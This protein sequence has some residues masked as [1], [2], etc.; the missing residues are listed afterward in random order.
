MY[1]FF[2]IL[3]RKV[4]QNTDE[5]MLLLLNVDVHIRYTVGRN[6][7]I[8]ALKWN[9]SFLNPFAYEFLTS[10]LHLNKIATVPL[11]SKKLD[12]PDKIVTLSLLN[13]FRHI[14][15]FLSFLFLKLSE[16][17]FVTDRVNYLFHGRQ[18]V[19]ITKSLSVRTYFAC[20]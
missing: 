7:H 13:H 20:K 9:L 18:Y 15:T 4:L 6:N 10:Y 17:I 3:C 16:P 2:E 19:T 1:F 8:L 11:N 14:L 12:I 5:K